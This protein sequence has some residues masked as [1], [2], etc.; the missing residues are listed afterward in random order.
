MIGSGGVVPPEWTD[1]AK[2]EGKAEQ[3]TAQPQ[4]L[5]GTPWDAIPGSAVSPLTI[6]PPK[7]MLHATF[8]RLS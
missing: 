4:S 6:D 1:M 7:R 2:G 5:S 3:T 8:V